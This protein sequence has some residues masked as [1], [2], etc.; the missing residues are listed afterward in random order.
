MSEFVSWLL[1]TLATSVAVAAA[2][3]YLGKKFIEH[4][5]AAS[6]KER[7]HLIN[8]R[9]EEFR[10]QLSRDATEHEIRFAKLHEK[11]FT[12][13]ADVYSRLVRLQR[14]LGEYISPMVAVGSP[15]EP[16]RLGALATELKLFFEYYSEHAV[17]LDEQTCK[18]L[19]EL[20]NEVKRS[21]ATFASRE[22]YDDR[23]KATDVWL[24]TLA[25]YQGP[26]QAIKARIESVFR[27]RLGVAGLLSAANPLG[28]PDLGTLPEGSPNTDSQQLL[29]V[30]T[31]TA[32]SAGHQTTRGAV[33][34]VDQ[35]TPE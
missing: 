9:L 20:T 28:A 33:K 1:H 3:G 21:V 26:I 8:K 30:K 10:H 14:C 29:D 5:L 4:M 13:M 6:A 16:E 22:L 17:F 24:Q 18:M 19:D 25:H 2:L 32:A 35:Q 12:V 15:S 23:K 11:A 7:D 27:Q 34:R 31:S